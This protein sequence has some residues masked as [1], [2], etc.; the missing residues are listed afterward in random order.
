MA[1]KAE[2]PP[3][4]PPP[5][6]SYESITDLMVKH[7][8]HPITVH[9]PNGI[10]PVAVAFIFLAVMFSVGSLELAAFYNMIFVV[11]TLPMVLFSGF[12]EL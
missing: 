3:A 10:V 7:H 2:T 1:S 6:L 12:N 5:L 4:S 9:F 11:L 8:I